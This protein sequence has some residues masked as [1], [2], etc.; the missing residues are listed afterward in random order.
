[1]WSALL[2]SVVAAGGHTAPQSS[3]FSAR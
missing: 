2:A 1:V 3:W